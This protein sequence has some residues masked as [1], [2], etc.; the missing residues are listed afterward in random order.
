M[1]EEEEEVRCLSEMR[2]NRKEKKKF[3]YIFNEAFNYIYFLFLLDFMRMVFLHYVKG[4]ERDVIKEGEK[5][6]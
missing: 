3:C 2:L 5:I 1:K 4:K 6:G